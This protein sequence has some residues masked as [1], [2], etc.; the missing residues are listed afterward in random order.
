[1][2]VLLKLTI[3]VFISSAA[4]PFKRDV[5]ITYMLVDIVNV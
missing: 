4:K 5:F 3:L 2:R 1:L